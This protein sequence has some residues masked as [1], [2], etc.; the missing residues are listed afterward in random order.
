M[1]LKEFRAALRGA[2]YRADVPEVIRLLKERAWPEEVLQLIGDALLVAVTSGSA[3][4]HGLTRACVAR[5]QARGW[6][7]DTDLAEALVARLRDGPQPLLRPVRV[8]LEELASVREGD[9]TRGG[10]RVD[11][12]TGQVWP[13]FVYEDFRADE[14]DEEEGEEDEAAGSRW[15]W[16]DPVGSRS[17]YRDMEVFI[18]S[19][20]DSHLAEVLSTAI[21]GQGAFRRFKDA[22]ARHQEAADRW[23][24]FSEDRVRGRARAWLAAEGYTPHPG[25]TPSPP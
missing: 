6:D 14:S 16:V 9:P 11:L 5:L 2:T 25:Q 18:G 19:L 13:Q 15:L 8:D 20:D 1:S 3:T 10:G 22:L 4:A 24:A 7:G 23:Y 17:G 12:A 21:S